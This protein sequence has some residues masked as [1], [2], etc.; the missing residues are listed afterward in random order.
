MADHPDL[1][2]EE[3]ARALEVFLATASFT[4]AAA[5]IGRNR[6]AVTAALRRATS[7]DVRQR[8]YART[9]DAVLSRAAALQRTAVRTLKPGVMVGDPKAVAALNDTAR[10]ASVTRTAQA[11]LIGSHAPEKIE[12]TH[13]VRD[14]IAAS[15]ARLAGSAEPDEAGGVR[16]ES[17]DE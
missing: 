12:T 4:K 8:V 9:L 1:T 5:A 15:L 17:D 2:P 6:P 13:D 10:T 11:K 7:D 3:L 14:S 16:R